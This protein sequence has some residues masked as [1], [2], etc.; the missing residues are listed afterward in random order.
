[1]GPYC[2]SLNKPHALSLSIKDFNN[3]RFHESTLM[4]FFSTVFLPGDWKDY[5]PHK[6]FVS[7]AT[8]KSKKA[9]FF[10]SK[11]QGD[12]NKG[13]ALRPY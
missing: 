3:T 2:C 11:Y 4:I 6:C 13:R 10:I 9:G 5:F 1:M 12:E 8:W 7:T